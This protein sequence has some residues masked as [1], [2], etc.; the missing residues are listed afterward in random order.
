MGFNPTGGGPVAVNSYAGN[1]ERQ[2]NVESYGSTEV[3]AAFSVN[4]SGTGIVGIWAGTGVPASSLGSNGD[5][6]LR[7]DGTEAGHTILYH[8]ESGAWVATA[9]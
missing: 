5:F 1:S 7:A 3:A 6:F 8:K 2:G 4:N 9:A